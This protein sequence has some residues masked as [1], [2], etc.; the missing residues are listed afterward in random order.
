MT[1]KKK[2]RVKSHHWTSGVLEV[3]NHI[4]DSLED[5]LE[6]IAGLFCHSAKIYDEDDNLIKEC[7]GNDNNTYA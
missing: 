6:Y 7:S 4:V 1:H 2:H 3:R 5:A